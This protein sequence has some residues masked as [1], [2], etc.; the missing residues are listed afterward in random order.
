MKRAKKELKTSA[1]FWMWAVAATSIASAWWIF[2]AKSHLINGIIDPWLILASNF[3]ILLPPGF[4]I[5]FVAKQYGKERALQEEYAFKSAI[6]ITLN[7]FADELNDA[8]EHPERLKLISE[9]VS[10][11]YAP[12]V[13]IQDKESSIKD[14]E[15]KALRDTISTLSDS[16]SKVSKISE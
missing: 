8:K 16:I 11:V 14:S 13:S 7:G 9:T 1:M 10:K 12:L 2:Y 15:N 3:G 5:G 4:L 6:A